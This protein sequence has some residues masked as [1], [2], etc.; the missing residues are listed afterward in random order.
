VLLGIDLLLADLAP[1]YTGDR[2]R[3]IRVDGVRRTARVD[4]VRRT[5]NAGRR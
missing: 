4:G 5:R 3:T 2:R 1:V